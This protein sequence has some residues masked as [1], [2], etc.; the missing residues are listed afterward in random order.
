MNEAIQKGV[1]LP[2]SNVFLVKKGRDG[3]GNAT[4][5][6]NVDGDR[7]FSIQSNGNLPG[8]HHILT[9]SPKVKSLTSEELATI[10]KEVVK[11]IKNY[12]TTKQKKWL[13]ESHTI[14]ITKS[15]LRSLI[16]ECICEETESYKQFFQSVLKKFNV[17]SPEELKGDK[18]AEFFQYVED[19][20]TTENPET[21]DGDEPTNENYTSMIWKDF[22][23]TID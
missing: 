20:W 12:G 10:S 5:V 17:T 23:N 9:P 22:K 11:Y 3:N 7:N 1:Q 18:K 16:E 15:Q 14:Q 4:V 6:V 19:N 13:R 2:N 21:N 8:T